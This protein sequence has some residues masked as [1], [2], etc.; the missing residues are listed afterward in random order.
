MKEGLNT[1]IGVLAGKTESATPPAENFEAKVQ[2]EVPPFISSVNEWM[3]TMLSEEETREVHTCMVFKWYWMM[4][5]IGY[6]PHNFSL[7]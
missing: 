3:N 5:Y 2:Q 6:V 4:I 1:L 7:G